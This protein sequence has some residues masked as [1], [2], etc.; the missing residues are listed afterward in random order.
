MRK[1]TPFSGSAGDEFKLSA[2]DAGLALSKVFNVRSAHVGY[3]A[4][5]GYGDARE[6]GDFAKVVHAHFDDGD[7]MLWLETEKLQRQP[8]AVVEVAL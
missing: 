2:C 8:E 6:R 5:V 3:D 7:L 4:P 1:A